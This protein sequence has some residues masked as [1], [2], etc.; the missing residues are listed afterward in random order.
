M[1]STVSMRSTVGTV[2]YRTNTERTHNT[3]AS[4]HSWQWSEKHPRHWQLPWPTSQSMGCCS[5]TGTTLSPSSGA[6]L[7]S[8]YPPYFPKW[9]TGNCPGRGGLPGLKTRRASY[10]ESRTFLVQSRQTPAHSS[11]RRGRRQHQGIG[12]ALDR[13]YPRSISSEPVNS[14]TKVGQKWAWKGIKRI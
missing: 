9:Q 14:V 2:S 10:P 1:I 4:A 7:G 5:W 13:Q 3:P 6:P 12:N 11:L 8:P